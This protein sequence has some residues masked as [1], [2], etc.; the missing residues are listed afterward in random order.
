MNSDDTRRATAAQ[1]LGKLGNANAIPA[2]RK[3]LRDPDASVRWSAALALAALKDRAALAPLLNYLRKSTD[4]QREGAALAL[5]TLGDT[6]AVP[7]LLAALQ[8][9]SRQLRDNIIHALGELRTPL[10]VD[11]LIAILAEREPRAGFLHDYTDLIG[12][13]HGFM[14]LRALM[15]MDG[16][17]QD[18]RPNNRATAAWA[19]GRIGNRRALPALTAARNDPDP[20]V[21]ER[22]GM[23]LRAIK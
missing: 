4:S 22:A 3:A 19:L 2:L 8:T 6:R 17:T 5:G 11:T 13:G 12:T 9:D 1:L 14:E 21:R 20:Q 16:I 7:A 18:P 10:A 15:E 23:A